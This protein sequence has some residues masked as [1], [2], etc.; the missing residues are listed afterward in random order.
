VRADPQGRVTHETHD[1]ERPE[2]VQ[3]APFIAIELL[4]DIAGDVDRLGTV[5]C[6]YDSKARMCCQIASWRRPSSPTP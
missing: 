4:E 6:P 3:G 2:T 5:S 1:P